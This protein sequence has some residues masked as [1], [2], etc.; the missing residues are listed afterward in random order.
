MGE[1]YTLDVCECVCVY[2]TAR[3][4][5]V[6]LEKRVPAG[7]GD[8]TPTPQIHP[9]TTASRGYRKAIKVRNGRPLVR[10]SGA[11]TASIR[12]NIAAMRLLQADKSVLCVLA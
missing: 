5:G 11:D 1:G 12:H 7:E 3:D 9:T 2:E 4:R 6:T 10:P 8:I